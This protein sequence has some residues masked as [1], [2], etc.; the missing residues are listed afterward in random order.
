MSLINYFFI[1][2][3]FTFIVD[4]LL[5]MESVK[6]H[7]ALENQE[8]GMTQRIL[9]IAIWPLSALVFLITF[10]KQFFK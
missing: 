6:S 3:G 2:A 5:S 4:L 8:W 10:I 7:P 9:C 1:G